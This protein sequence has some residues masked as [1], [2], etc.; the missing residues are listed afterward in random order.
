[1]VGCSV[2]NAHPPPALPSTPVLNLVLTCRAGQGRAVP[3]RRCDPPA[4]GDQGEREQP[5]NHPLRAEHVS[6]ISA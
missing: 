1:M 3:Q 5:V 2:K 4:Q 6:K